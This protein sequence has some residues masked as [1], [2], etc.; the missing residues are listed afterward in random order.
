[1]NCLRE[2]DERGFALAKT[3]GEIFEES[4]YKKTPSYFFILS[5]M[6]SRGASIMDSASLEDPSFSKET[7]LQEALEGTSVSKGQVYSPNEMHWIGYVYRIISYCYEIRS[8]KLVKLVPPS[9]LRSVY[10]P[11]HTLDPVKATGLI[12][13]EREVK[14]LSKEEKI[15]MIFKRK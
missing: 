14:L 11:Y 2:I 12:L 9:Y 4:V 3:Q 15:K 6:R 8:I 13:E 10:L 7:A 1:M 5:F